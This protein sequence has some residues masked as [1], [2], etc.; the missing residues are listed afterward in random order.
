MSFHDLERPAKT[1]RQTLVESS[2]TPFAPADD[3]RPVVRVIDGQ[4]TNADLEPVD[5]IRALEAAGGDVAVYLGLAADHEWWLAYD[6]DG[7][8]PDEFDGPYLRWSS[9]PTGP[10][11]CSALPRAIARSSLELLYA[12]G[13]C[14]V[15][16]SRVVRLEDAPEFVRREVGA[17]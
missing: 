17:E 15:R 11:E 4:R 8:Y 10:W 5:W 1:A 6:P 13:R 2:G 7:E 12:D 14:D 9:Y 16:R 3:V